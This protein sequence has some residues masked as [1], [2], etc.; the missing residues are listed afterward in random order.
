[1]KICTLPICRFSLSLIFVL[2]ISAT[3]FAQAIPDRVLVVNGKT[4]GTPVRQIDGRSY[5]DIETLAQVTNGVFT[6]EPNAS[7]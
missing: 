4:A 6:V 3:L 7:F 2:A 1:M 5:I